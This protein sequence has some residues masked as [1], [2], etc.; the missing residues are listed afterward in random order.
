ME[1]D[2]W[3]GGPVSGSRSPG[4]EPLASEA[5]PANDKELSEMWGC[6]AVGYL[7]V[8]AATEAGWIQSDKH[9]DKRQM[10]Q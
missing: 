1:V 6:G 9:N 10:T 8:F 2:G 5:S 3:Q 4:V 7:Q